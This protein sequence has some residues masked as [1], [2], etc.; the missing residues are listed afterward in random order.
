MDCPRVSVLL[1]EQPHLIQKADEVYDRPD[2][3][4]SH[5]AP[6]GP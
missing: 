2:A 1:K 3:N 4:V 6:R 5:R